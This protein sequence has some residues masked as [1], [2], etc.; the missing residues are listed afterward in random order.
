MQVELA[1][2]LIEK[3][4]EDAQQVLSN[5]IKLTNI[6]ISKTTPDLHSQEMQTEECRTKLKGCFVAALIESLVKNDRWTCR[7]LIRL[8]LIFL[9]QAASSAK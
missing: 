9:K 4:P 2:L 3:S 7:L 8:I 1:S 5:Q 6:L